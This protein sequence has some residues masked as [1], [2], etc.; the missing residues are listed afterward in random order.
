MTII[1]ELKGWELIPLPGPQGIWRGIDDRNSV[2]I[3]Y[4][5]VD[6]LIV[7]S[8]CWS[9]FECANNVYNLKPMSQLN[10]LFF[11]SLNSWLNS[12]QNLMGECRP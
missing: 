12:D 8:R 11:L 10:S 7:G 3:K 6:H 1:F 5:L 2:K 4:Y 9:Y